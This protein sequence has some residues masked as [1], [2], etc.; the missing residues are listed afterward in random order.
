[1]PLTPAP[2]AELAEP[3]ASFDE[4]I[5]PAK[6]Q[7][8]DPPTA[9]LVGESSFLR[10]VRSWEPVSDVEAAAFAG[11]FAC[12]FQSFD[13]DVPWR[14]AEV[15]REVLA[16]A[17]ACTWGWSGSGRQRADSPLPGRIYR[18]SDTVVFVEVVV[19]VTSYVRAGAVAGADGHPENDGERG[20]WVEPAGMIGRSCAP[21]EADSAWAAA[22]AWWVRMTVPV[23]RAGED[24]RLV[25]DPGLLSGPA[26]EQA[27]ER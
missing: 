11:R 23:T 27:G 25:V 6:L 19:R 14:R 20:E 2:A 8:H 3:Q 22:Q 1:M 26:G 5:P 18:R 10:S 17:Q 7:R 4:E 21:P 13:E 15:L 9:R 16:D 24:G 12:D